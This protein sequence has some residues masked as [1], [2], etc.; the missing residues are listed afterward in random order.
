MY[1][2]AHPTIS[3]RQMSNCFA[4]VLHIIILIIF[5][6]TMG[7]ISENVINVLRFVKECW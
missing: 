2:S 5:G 3:N 6:I 1:C 4:N 7:D